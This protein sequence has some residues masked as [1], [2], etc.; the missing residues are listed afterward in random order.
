MSSFI[1][2]VDL[3]WR[4]PGQPPKELLTDINLDIS[5]N[6]IC[7]IRGP[8][9]SSKS[10]LLGMMA[11]LEVPSS[12]M[13]TYKKQNI[14]RLTPKERAACRNE[15]VYIPEDPPSLWDRTVYEN[16]EYILKYQNIPSDVIFDRI[17]HLLKLTGLIGKRDMK[18]SRLSF[19]EKKVFFMAAALAT[20]KSAI[21]CDLNIAGLPDEK[22]II[23]AVKNYVLRGGTI[24]MTAK[25]K[26]EIQTAHTKYVD[27]KDGKIK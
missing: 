24:V 17:M 7:L 6:D 21:F 20:E 18:P 26:V 3:Y 10:I 19:I 16:I 4:V 13:L 8:S 14:E 12:G 5:D 23:R 15:I 1:S 2:A 9:G 27:I 22:D 25:E 11:N